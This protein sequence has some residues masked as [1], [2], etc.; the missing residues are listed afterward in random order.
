[1]EHI[2]ARNA[3]RHIDRGLDNQ[4]N[5]LVSHRPAYLRGTYQHK[6]LIAAVDLAAA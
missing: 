2:H 4:R 5:P 6:N 1:M 3:I